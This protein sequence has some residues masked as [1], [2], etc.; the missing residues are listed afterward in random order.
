MENASEGLS[1]NKKSREEM[2]RELVEL[3]NSLVPLEE[4]LAALVPLD[5][6]CDDTV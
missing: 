4:L 1:G 5:E 3:L 2:E 6:L